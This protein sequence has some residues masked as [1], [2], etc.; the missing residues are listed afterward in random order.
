MHPDTT[1]HRSRIYEI[2]SYAFAEPSHDFLCFISS[3]EFLEY[4]K[5]TTKILKHLERSELKVL[6][7][8][9]Q[10]SQRTDL[11]LINSEYNS[12]TSPEKNYFYECNYYAPA[13]AMEELADIAGFYRAFGVAPDCERPDYISAELEFMKLLT[14]K[15]AK[16]ILNNEAA[17]AEICLSAQKKF[18]SS[19]LGRWVTAL[20]EITDTLKFYSL[21]CRFLNTWIDAE[22]GH[23]SVF[24]DKNCFFSNSTFNENQSEF[25]PKKEGCI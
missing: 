12:L 17:N 8:A 3:G 18:L 11:T 19:H 21:L 16:A 25:C 24:P 1:F 10:L 7:H 4:I 2:L 15:E 9:H 22:C 20:S 5:K 23:L 6:E 13:N 14:M